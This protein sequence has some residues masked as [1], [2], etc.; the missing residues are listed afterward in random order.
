VTSKDK[1][2]TLVHP[3]SEQH[4]TVAEGHEDIYLTQGWEISSGSKAKND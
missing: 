2:L 3:D 1:T 4:I